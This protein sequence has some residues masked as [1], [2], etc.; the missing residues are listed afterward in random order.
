MN[1]A[2]FGKTM[3]NVR[4]RVDVEL[5]TQWEGRYGAEV[6]IAKPNFHSIFSENLIAIELYKFEVKFDKLIYVGI[7]ILDISKRLYE[8]HHKYGTAVSRKMQNY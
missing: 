3:E 2:I 8:F 5:L 1:N 4:D 7:C 6:M